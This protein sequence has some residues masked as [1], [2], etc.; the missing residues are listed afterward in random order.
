MAGGLVVP[1]NE[2][3]PSPVTFAFRRGSKAK[4][5]ENVANGLVGNGLAEIG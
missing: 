1:A 5:F 3:G 4:A 2:R